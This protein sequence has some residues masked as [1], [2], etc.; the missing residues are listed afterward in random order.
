MS[1]DVRERLRAALSAALEQRDAARLAVLRT[2]LAALD[3]AEAVPDQEHDRG[4]LALEAV[5]I[6]VG[7]REVA[8]RELA[9]EDVERL[10][11]AEIG[12]RQDAARVYEQAGRHE[13]ARR[14]RQEADTPA[15]AAGLRRGSDPPTARR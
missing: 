11:R 8:R 9:D 7:T 4:S 15:E 10:V 3:N 14:L 2:A 5:P 12:G 6:G 13:R 1:T